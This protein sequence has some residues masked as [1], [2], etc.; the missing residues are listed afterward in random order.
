MKILNK[1]KLQ[2]TWINHS[3]DIY[4]KDFMKIYKKNTVKRYSF[5]VKDKISTSDNPLRFRENLLEWIYDKTMIID[6]QIENKKLEYNIN[7]VAAKMS[8]LSSGKTNKYKY[9]TAEEIL[10]FNK[11][12][13]RMS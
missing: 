11:K 1:G 7:R 12:G 4:F 5:L 13:N 9:F 6:D 3:S 2:Q 10:P 8:A